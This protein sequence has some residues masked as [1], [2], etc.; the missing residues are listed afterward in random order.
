MEVLIDFMHYI[1]M[2]K[3]TIQKDIKKLYLPIKKL[4]SQTK[5]S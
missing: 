1:R 3:K 5:T 2:S 4:P